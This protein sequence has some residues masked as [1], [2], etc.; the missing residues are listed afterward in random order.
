M[1]AFV[2]ALQSLRFENCFNPYSD[3]CPDCDRADAPMRRASVLSRILQAV[4][5]EGVDAIWVGRDLGYRGGRRTGL[6][7]TDDVHIGRHAARWGLAEERFTLGEA[8]A[9]R[10]AAVIWSVLDRIDTRLFLWNVFPLHPH[11]NGKPFSNR[12]HNGKERQVGE[13]ALEQLI[14]LARPRRIV[15]IGADAAAAASRVAA[16][17]PVFGVRHPSYGGQTQF[18][19]QISDLYGLPPAKTGRMASDSQH[20]PE[21]QRLELEFT[22]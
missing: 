2:S 20:R 17:V 9:E 6:A 4:E 13:S 22:L 21:Q 12:P 10:T 19:R 1:H 16:D 18:L 3:R 5:S 7:L 8:I 14:A 11:D 15:A